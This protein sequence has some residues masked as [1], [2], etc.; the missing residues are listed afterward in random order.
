[1]QKV[2]CAC[3]CADQ[4]QAAGGGEGHRAAGGGGGDGG[5]ALPADGRRQGQRAAALAALP[6]G[7]LLPMFQ[8]KTR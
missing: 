8:P 7:G 5:R 2:C 1:M 6:A 4:W 3:L